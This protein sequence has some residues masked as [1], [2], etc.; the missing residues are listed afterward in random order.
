MNVPF[1]RSKGGGFAA[2]GNAE[3]VLAGVGCASRAVGE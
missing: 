1:D 2:I 3:K